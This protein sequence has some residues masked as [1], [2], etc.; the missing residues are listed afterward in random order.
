MDYDVGAHL[1][2]DPIMQWAAA[3]WD[4][5]A[6]HNQLQLTWRKAMTTVAMAAKPFSKVAGPAGAYVASAHRLGWKTPSWCHILLDDNTMINLTDIAPRDLKALAFRSWQRR[7]AQ[8][9]KLACTMGG[10]PD[11][12]PLR[13]FVNKKGLSHKVA[14]SL[15]SLGEGGWWTQQRMYEAKLTG[16]DTDLCQ[17]CHLQ[18]GTLYHRCV[19]CPGLNNLLRNHQRHTHTVNTAR[20]ASHHNHP[21]YQHGLPTLKGTPKPPPLVTRWCGGVQVED[22]TF[23]GDVYSDGSV[24]GGCRAGCERGGWAGVKVNEDGQVIFGVYGTCP[25]WSPSSLRA[26]LWALLMV[27]RHAL[28]PI[29]IWVDNDSVVKGFKKGKA[30]C[31]CS[32]RPAADLWDKIW[33][34]VADLGEQ[35]IAVKKV[36]GHASQA[37]VDAG[38]ATLLRKTGNDHAD[39][40]AKRGSALSEHLSNTHQQRQDD[41][42]ARDWYCWLATLTSD[43]PKDT[44]RARPPAR[45]KRKRKRPPEGAA[46]STT[47]ATAAITAASTTGRTARAANASTSRFGSGHRLYKSGG[48]T[49]CSICG[50]YAAERFKALKKPCQG[51]AGKGPRAGQLARLLKGEHPLRRGVPLPRAVRVG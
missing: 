45:G 36:R 25:D 44:Q 46:D 22:P 41:R 3:V 29:T 8:H 37:D 17:V 9:T 18:A 30:W 34:K 11:F 28:P 35:G 40:F 13:A 14:S 42:L 12:E 32:R 2:S 26:E 51:P 48:L 50:A 4:K 16:V 38:L 5:L 19:A 24:I 23:E 21:L 20:L 27:L 47:A 31:V 43:W 1:A 7:E 33:A 10:A 39:H 6:P 49:W 15:R